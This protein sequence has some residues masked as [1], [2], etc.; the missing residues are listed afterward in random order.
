MAKKKKKKGK[1]RKRRI[2]AKIGD[3]LQRQMQ[4]GQT[5]SQAW[6]T[7][8]SGILQDLRGEE[9]AERIG[10]FLAQ[11]DAPTKAQFDRD[12]TRLRGITSSVRF[13]KQALALLATV[14]DFGYAQGLAKQGATDDPQSR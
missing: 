8:G 6:T 14:Y 11:F 13:K 5:E 12:I 4:K 10:I 3:L 9:L 7:L 2:R 1:P